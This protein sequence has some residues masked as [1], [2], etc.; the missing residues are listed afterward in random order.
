MTREEVDQGIRTLT[1]A[2][3]R[4]STEDGRRLLR[5]QLER[6]KAAVPSGIPRYVG[7]T[8]AWEAE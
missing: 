1:L 6:F 4:A 3:D 7:T 5:E 8:Q 2:I